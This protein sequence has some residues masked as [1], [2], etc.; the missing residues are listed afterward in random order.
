MSIREGSTVSWPWGGG[1]GSGTVVEIHRSTVTRTLAG[2]EI[3]RHGSDGDPAYLI[4]TGD[5]ARVLK[6]RSEVTHD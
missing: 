3:T 6:L 5:G 1:R 2:S 4:E